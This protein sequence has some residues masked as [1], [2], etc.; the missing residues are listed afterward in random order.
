MVKNKGQY[1]VNYWGRWILKEVI[2][3]DIMG[4]PNLQNFENTQFYGVSDADAYLKSLYRDY[5]AL[6]PVDKR[7]LHIHGMF[8][9]NNQ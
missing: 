1:I 7:N 3:K 9:K 8:W 5:M 6:P 2:H 4:E